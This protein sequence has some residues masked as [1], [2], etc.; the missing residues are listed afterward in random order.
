[1]H[2]YTGCWVMYFVCVCVCVCLCVLGTDG[3]P[4]RG[5][6][7]R[8]LRDTL[9]QFPAWGVSERQSWQEL[10]DELGPT[11][12][13]VRDSNCCTTGTP[14]NQ[15]KWAKDSTVRPPHLSR[16]FV[17]FSKANIWLHKTFPWLY[18]KFT[19]DNRK[20]RQCWLSYSAVRVSSNTDITEKRKE[21]LNGWNLASTKSWHWI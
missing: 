15:R 13:P 5:L 8:P 20:E 21:R 12:L 3:V 2:Q 17:S 19:G 6:C 10:L 14:P 16:C 11:D 7:I 4:D 1:M 18:N 9:W